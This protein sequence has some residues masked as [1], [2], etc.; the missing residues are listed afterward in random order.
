M[1]NYYR[2]KYSWLTVDDFRRVS[3]SRA[4]LFFAWLRKFV[5]PDSYVAD[6]S[7]LTVVEPRDVHN[8]WIAAALDRMIAEARHTGLEALF[9]L[10]SPQLAP[11]MSGVS[12][13]LLSEDRRFGASA[14][15]SHDTVTP[16][17][18]FARFACWS[19]RS[20]G[21]VI[22][23][24]NV[25]SIMPLPPQVTAEWLSGASVA[26]VVARHRERLDG[27]EQL[28]GPGKDELLATVMEQSRA[29]TEYLR[30]KG[31]LRPLTDAEVEEI[32]RRPP[33]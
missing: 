6:P 31:Y 12:A 28:L 5:A 32:R 26:E 9:W 16:G 14:V 17:L 18:G 27:S 13:E 15:A 11:T 21:T 20:D 1:T 4:E 23:T 2:F 25:K 24:T 33:T 10:H 30:K 22:S 8:T 7:L 19:V 3:H 29:G